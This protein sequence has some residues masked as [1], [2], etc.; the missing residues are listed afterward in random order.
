M[1]LSEYIELPREERQSHLNLSTPCFL[2]G[3]GGGARLRCRKALLAHLGV[4]DNV[5]NWRTAR[6]QICHSCECHSKNGYCE[7]P[8][9]ISVGTVQENQTDIPFTVRQETGRKAGRR[10]AE[11]GAGFHNP[12]VRENN[13][14][15]QR[16][17]IQVTHIES[18]G[19]VTFKSVRLA[20][21]A[22]GLNPGHLSTMCLGK[23]K[24]HKGYTAQHVEV[25][26]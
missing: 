22:L 1:D 5:P 25:G 15:K 13:Y 17:A 9:H 7:N 6:I 23:Q 8:L 14:R 18:G 3:G 4:E 11:L 24:T 21:W 20:A 19:T 2:N 12:E 26:Q 10:S 16:K